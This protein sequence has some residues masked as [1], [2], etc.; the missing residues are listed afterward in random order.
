MNTFWRLTVLFALGAVWL[1]VFPATAA[2][3]TYSSYSTWLAATTGSPT[4]V[5]FTA[6]NGT[7]Y[8]DSF[9]LTLGT[10]SIA[11]RNGP[12]AGSYS[13]SVLTGPADDSTSLDF[14]TGAYARLGTSAFTPTQFE[15]ILGG[16][17]STAW[18]GEIGGMDQ[19]APDGNPFAFIPSAFGYT[20]TFY[21]GA[22]QLYSASGTTP[23]S[24][25]MQFRGFTSTE[26]VTSILII[27]NG[28]GNQRLALDNFS[29]GALLDE[30]P[31]EAPE[32]SVLWLT[33][34]GLLLLGW[35]KLLPSLAPYLGRWRNFPA[36]AR[37]HSVRP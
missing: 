19:V 29:Y 7:S 22:T 12:S 25:S 35:K 23:S 1:G 3:V 31:A 16:G 24:D 26:A 27:S 36:S 13:L 33:G 11:G 28:S 18:S 9:G 10:L 14:G 5:D 8:G 4:T 30:P 15:I 20:I 6:Q 17:G 37:L 34:G 21:N 32:A 2:V